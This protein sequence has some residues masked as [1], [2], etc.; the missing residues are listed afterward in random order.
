MSS[1]TTAHA[2]VL[3]FWEKLAIADKM[4][5]EYKNVGCQGM[6]TTIIRCFLTV[7]SRIAAPE[8]D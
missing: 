5:A 1:A 7:S 6:R 4:I 2:D 8:M 3:R